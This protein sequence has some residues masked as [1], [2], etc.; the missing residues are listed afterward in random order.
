MP[1]RLQTRIVPSIAL[2]V[3]LVA[4]GRGAAQATGPDLG[5]LG[6]TSVIRASLPD[7]RTLTGRYAAVG[8]GRLG[9]RADAGT[10]DTLRLDQ[11]RTLSVRGRHTKT[12]AIVGGSLGLATGL[13]FGYLIGAICD[14][15][16]CDRGEPYLVTIPL[17]TGGGTLLGAVI[18]A[19]VPKWKQ[20]YP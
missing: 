5:R 9:V 19:A 20:V 10:T 1:S 11:L 15:A 16:D 4:P 3:A 18:G 14:S 17:F 2:L 7:G 6:P 8:D 13:F 12:G